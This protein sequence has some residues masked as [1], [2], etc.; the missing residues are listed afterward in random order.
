MAGLVMIRLFKQIL[1]N[2]RMPEEWRSVLVVSFNNNG[3]L[4][5]CRRIHRNRV[6][7]H[8][9]VVGKSSKT[10]TKGRSEDS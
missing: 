5:T 8:N 3:E 7:P 10:Q 6:K 4:Q 9:E 2:E 1:E